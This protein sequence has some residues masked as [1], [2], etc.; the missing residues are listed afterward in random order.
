[1][2]NRLISLLKMCHTL[3]WSK[4]RTGMY[5]LRNVNKFP[6]FRRVPRLAATPLPPSLTAPGL[7]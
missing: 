7:R 1:M 3:D 2:K 5:S 6:K 4:D